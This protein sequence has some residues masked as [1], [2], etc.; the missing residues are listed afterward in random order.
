VVRL[1]FEFAPG[2]GPAAGLERRGKGTALEFF[3]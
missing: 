2:G 1:V 3:R